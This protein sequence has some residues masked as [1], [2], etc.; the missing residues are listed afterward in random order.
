MFQTSFLWP[1]SWIP[2]QSEVWFRFS[3]LWRFR[4][5]LEE[6]DSPL[7]RHC[8]S[9]VHSK[10]LSQECMRGQDEHLYRYWHV[11]WRATLNT[12]LLFCWL[13]IYI[14]KIHNYA[15]NNLQLALSDA[16]SDMR[17]QWGAHP[18]TPTCH[19]CNDNFIV[20]NVI[21]FNIQE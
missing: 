11:I 18:L 16:K 5:I 9:Q 20:Q 15:K 14:A 21:L 8:K 7:F 12:R 3:F 19:V 17:G 13:P 2:R 6:G 1:C 4:E 10:L